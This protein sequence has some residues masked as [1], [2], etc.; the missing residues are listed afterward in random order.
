MV[1]VKKILINELCLC[2]PPKFM[3]LMN[4]DHLKKHIKITEVTK[5]FTHVHPIDILQLIQDAGLNFMP[6]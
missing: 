2:A 5:E 6:S 3:G 4:K 1:E